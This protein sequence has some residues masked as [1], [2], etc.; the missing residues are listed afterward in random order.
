MRWIKE[1]PPRRKDARTPV[2]VL[3]TGHRGYIGSVLTSVL[4]QARHDVVGLDS[5]LYAGCDFGRTR[6]DV[7]S[8]D[9]DVREIEFTDLLSFDA[10]I[11]L[12]ALPE[13]F[14]NFIDS[15]VT[16]EVNCAATVRLAECCK[17]A[18]VGR[19]LFA[20][21]CAV[22]GS[23]G[24]E[25]QYEDSPPRPMSPYA[26]AKLCAEEKLL[27]LA[28]AGF[29]P[30]LL[31][32]ATVYGVSPRMRLDT[33]VNDFVASASAC[34]RVGVQTNG[35]AWR[36]LIHVEDVARAYAAVLVAPAKLVDR[37]VL[38]LAITEEN[39]RV[40]DVA[41]QVADLVAGCTRSLR[42]AT[43]DRRS[44][45][46]DGSKLRAALPHFE[47]RW[48]LPHGIRQLR[49]AMSGAGLT[50]S[51]WRSDRY[52]RL[53]RLHGLLQRGDVAADLRPR[54]REMLTRRSA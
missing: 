6:D 33:V 3:V 8:F 22:Y 52:R 32:N 27:K 19:L 16:W 41:D 2:R 39:Y 5:E 29:A 43:P 7:P 12:A 9:T 37:Q 34:G 49:I 51:D 20:S 18:S 53:D 47:W 26:L 46:V 11:H 1:D 40:V 4:K 23:S 25:P 21:T 10:V 44:Y 13:D 31:R 36:P 35:L 24:D 50:P 42:P 45:F 17:R 38:N 48:T 28:D 14:E 54:R 15:A 30:I